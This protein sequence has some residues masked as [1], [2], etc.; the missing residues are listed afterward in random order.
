M[1]ECLVATRSG[2]L[3]PRHRMRVKRRMDDP[4]RKEK[5]VQAANVHPSS[6]ASNPR[7][8]RAE[9][10]D[11]RTQSVSTPDGRGDTRNHNGKGPG[12]RK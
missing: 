5:P 1:T 6:E 7:D 9:K 4:S 12:G 8:I 11:G 2:G 10:P 3:Q